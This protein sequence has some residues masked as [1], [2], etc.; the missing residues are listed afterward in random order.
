MN[1]CLSCINCK[2]IICIHL[3]GRVTGFQFI[4]KIYLIDI[5]CIWEGMVDARPPLTCGLSPGT[6]AS[7][8]PRAY[9]RANKKYKNISC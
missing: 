5:C 9:I 7:L 8:T 3:L 2:I 4:L 6:P 1:G